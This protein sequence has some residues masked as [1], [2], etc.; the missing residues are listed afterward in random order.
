MTRT[1]GNIFGSRVMPEGT[2]IWL[3][4]SISYARFDAT[5]GSFTLLQADTGSP[6]S[7]RPSL[8]GAAS[9]KS[10]SGPT[11]ATTSPRPRPRC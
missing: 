8:C 3:N 2:G 10:P 4:N 11:V 7:H 9:P 6:A 1:L 5:D